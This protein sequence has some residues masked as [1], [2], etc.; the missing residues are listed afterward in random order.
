MCISP[1]NQCQLTTLIQI[2]PCQ[3]W[4][5]LYPIVYFYVWRPLV[6]MEM[7]KAILGGQL[8]SQFDIFVCSECMYIGRL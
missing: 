1:Y 5:L 2:F 8:E 3:P 6:V 7:T 4:I